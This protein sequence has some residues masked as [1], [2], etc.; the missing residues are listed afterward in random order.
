MVKKKEVFLFVVLLML[1]GL[2][3]Y[4]YDYIKEAKIEMFDKIEKDKINQV[5]DIY[6]N[7]KRTTVKDE[8]ISTESDMFKF[9][10][11][12]QN[13][14][15]Q[16]KKIAT[17]LSPSIKYIYI[18]IRDKRGRFRYLIDASKIDKANYYQKFDVDSPKYN[19][20]YETKKPQII[21]HKDGVENLCLTYLYPLTINGKVV[22]IL[23]FDITNYLKKDIESLIKPLENFFIILMVFIVLLILMTV[24][25]VIHYF[26][27]RK[28][29]FTDPLT[30]LFNRNYLQEIMP[31]LNLE[32]YSI[33]ML[34][35]DR[36]K[37]VNDTYG[38]KAGDYV[39][40][41]SSEIFKHS[42][43]ETDILIR[44]GGEEFLLFIYNR[45]NADI[46][47]EICERI[48][49]N[50]SENLYTFDNSDINMSVSIGIHKKP[51][52]EKNLTEAIKKADKMLY[53][54]K[55]E[56]RNRVIAFEENIKEEEEK[57]YDINF[58]KE[59]IL[60]D[61]VMCYYQPIYDFANSKIIKYEALVRIKDTNGDIIY[62]M[63]FLPNLK[64]TNIHYKLTQRILSL[65][66]D[67]FKNN[68]KSVSIN[69]SFLDLIN[70]DIVDTIRDTL[71]DNIAFAKRITFEI[72]ESDEIENI[73]LF[74]NKIKF[75]HDLGSKIS[76]DDFGSGY[77]NFRTVLDIEADYL[78]IDGSLIKNID[79]NDK[80]YKVV[81]SII[82]FAKVSNMST[83]A[84][85]VH[86]KDVYDKLK[87]LELDYMQGYYIAK[88]LAKIA[89]EDDLFKD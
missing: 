50:I 79:K 8:N 17:L 10:S 63:S 13:R 36:F 32:H 19:L 39:L 2:M 23:T 87:T 51:Y 80:D 12:K 25:Q 86:S 58:V 45:D 61:R 68:D 74:K 75:L 38:H 1:G 70:K 78:K 77:S 6:N 54:A 20:V 89:T 7:I 57:S 53:V 62:P 42:I 24:I 71:G 9:L 83:I 15:S 37:S 72:L 21:R 48:R 28:K 11:K 67:K 18:L 81:E 52:L 33:A 66:F 85:F 47:M 41:K 40:S 5:V 49:K 82:H 60:D 14:I 43:R 35:L 46:S 59:A 65:I 56:G 30:K 64:H 22:A 31:M 26:V 84:E 55:S 73:E 34:D 4:I 3:I 69:L 88:P 76:V 29:I 27:T 16:E 44:Y